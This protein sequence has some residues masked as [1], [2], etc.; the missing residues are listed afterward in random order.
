MTNHNFHPFSVTFNLFSSGIILGSRWL[1]FEGIL[2]YLK[3]R[4]KLGLQFYDL[5]SD[6]PMQIISPDELPVKQTNRLVHASVAQ[7]PKCVFYSYVVLVKR[8]DEEYCHMINTK[9]KKIQIDRGH[10]RN[11]FMRLP[12]VITPSAT[13]YVNGDRAEIERLLPHLP[14]LGKKIG[15]GGLIRNCVIEDMDEDYSLIKGDLAMRS[16]PL[17]LG[18]RGSEIMYLPWHAPYWAKNA[19]ACVAPGAKVF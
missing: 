13:F 1:S 11:Y 15:A 19:A 17:S 6:R 5:P 7:F 9:V 3:A 16:L 2:T 10:F 14:G 12:Y 18:Y 4:E 8:F